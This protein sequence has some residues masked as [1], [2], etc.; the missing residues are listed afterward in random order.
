MIKEFGKLSEKTENTENTE[1]PDFLD[2]LAEPVR[3]FDVLIRYRFFIASISFQS[4]ALMS[5]ENQIPDNVKIQKE[6]LIKPSKADSQ[7]YV[8]AANSISLNSFPNPILLSIPFF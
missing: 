2:F 6:N 7:K 8:L 5:Q 1:S 3:N 4:L